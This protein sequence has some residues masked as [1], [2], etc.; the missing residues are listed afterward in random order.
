MWSSWRI[1]CL[2][3]L[4]MCMHYIYKYI[5]ICVYSGRALSR[6]CGLCMTVHSLHT[7]GLLVLLGSPNAADRGAWRVNFWTP[8]TTQAYKQ[9]FAL[10][11]WGRVSQTFCRSKF[12]CFNRY[13]PICTD[14]MPP[15][16]LGWICAAGDQRIHQW[17]CHH[18]RPQ[19]AKAAWTSQGQ[20]MGAP[21]ALYR[22]GL[23]VKGNNPGVKA[24]SSI[25]SSNMF[26]FFHVP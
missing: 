17:S 5:Y 19:S 24:E 22:I 16:V 3:L 18:H 1:A 25:E 23:M 21:W 15:S 6:A 7:W 4:R 20:K 13:D 14:L 12:G 2:V 11:N 8:T 10:T 9:G 26:L